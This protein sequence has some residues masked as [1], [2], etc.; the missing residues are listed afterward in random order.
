MKKL[1]I[2]SIS[3][4]IIF[5]SCQKTLLGPVVSNTPENNFEEMWKGYDA[6]YG[7]FA[8]RSINWDSVYKTL[9]HEVN[10]NLT[11]RQ[12]YDV[13]S[14][15]ITPLNDIHVF[16]QPTS[17][18]LPRYESNVF[19]RNNKVQHDFSINVIKQNY[20]PQ[21][22][23]IDDNLHYGI[24][25]GNIG[26][27]HFGGFGMP[28]SFYKQKMPEIMNTLKNTKAMIVDIRNHSGGDD[29]VSQYVAGWFAKDRALFMT[30]RKRNGPHRNDFTAPD[31]W[32]VDKQGGYQYTNAVVLLTTRWTASAGETFTWAMNTQPQVTQ[33]GDTTAG[34]FTDVISR[35][36]PNG[37]LYFVGVG[38]YRNADGNSEEGIGVAP[39][40]Y[41]VNTKS[42]IDAG[43]DKVLE[44][45]IDRVK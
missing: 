23:T 24:L 43:R 28:L 3:L 2:I 32:Y 27:L 19:F 22:V 15:M 38:D 12:L 11:Q 41:A 13:L 9:R 17:D 18:D 1:S 25:D 26:Y 39:Q 36:L 31:S 14:R 6:W 10:N 35:E 30:S 21:L 7:G 40:L 44:E 5:T 16:L 33:M 34:G 42:D 4:I 37:W 20:L 45:A 29:E 8:V